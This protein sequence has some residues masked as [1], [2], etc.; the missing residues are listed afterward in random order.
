MTRW[1]Y[2]LAADSVIHLSA[3]FCRPLQNNAIETAKS[4]PVYIFR[5]HESGRLIFRIFISRSRRR[6][7][8]SSFIRHG[9][10]N[11]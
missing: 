11:S 1:S 9:V 6:H 7:C 3:F 10:R 5:G 4:A 2:D 8:L